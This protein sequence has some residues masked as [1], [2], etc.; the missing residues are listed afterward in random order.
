MESN[1]LESNKLESLES[2]YYDP[3]TGYSG[4]ND[5]QRKSGKSQKEVT[6]FLHQQDTYTLHKPARKNYKTQRVFVHDIDEQW[7]SDLVEMIPYAQ[8]NNNFKYLLTVIDCFS[9]YGWIIPLKNKT[10]E[11]TTKAFENLFKVRKPQKIQTDNGKEYYNSK[12]SKLFKDMNINHFS[13]TS[14]KKASICERF[15]RTI[16]EKMWKIFTQN[17][18]HKWIDILDKLTEN[19][20]N[21][22]HRSIKMTPIEG[23]KKENRDIVDKNLFPKTE[24]SSCKLKPNFKVG[25]IVRITRYKKIFD[26]GYLPNWTTEK[27]VVDKVFKTDPITYEI[28]DMAGELITGKFYKEEL[29]LF[30][31]QN[32]LYKVEKI[33]KRRTHNGIKEV[34]VKWYGYPEKFNS[35]ISEQNF[36]IKK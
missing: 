34:F 12:L 33:L 8:E 10:G 20:N 36:V 6:E 25:D 21:S 15:N 16:K 30:D 32:N 27:F 2:L 35:W 13:T 31:S 7:Q 22:L 18:N 26:K 1:K 17:N 28:K 9:K 29:T 4:I 14:D 23:S 24:G 3:K 5:L 19:Y 11:E